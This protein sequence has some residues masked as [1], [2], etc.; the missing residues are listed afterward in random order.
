MPQ[1]PDVRK[2][3][4]RGISDFRISGQSLTKENCHNSRTSDDIYMKLEPV[5]KL[6]KR[7]KTSKKL[8]DDAM[9]ENY[10]IIMIFPI[11][12]HLGQSGSQILD[13]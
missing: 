1:S 5:T 9:L 13:A 8:D 7:N 11:Y 4:D 6:N 10:D 3:S 12:G 2:N